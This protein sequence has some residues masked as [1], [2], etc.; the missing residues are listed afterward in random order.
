MR[1]VPG[2]FTGTSTDIVWEE[3]DSAI[4][5]T[6]R[7]RKV[8]DEDWEEIADTANQYT[9]EDLEDSI[10]KLKLEFLVKKAD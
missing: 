2:N 1:R 6:L 3:V 5:Y 8:G 4:A 7:H 10:E 9:L